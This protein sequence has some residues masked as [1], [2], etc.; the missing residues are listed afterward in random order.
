MLASVGI[1]VDIIFAAGVFRFNCNLADGFLNGKLPAST[2]THAGV[3]DGMD[4][5]GVGIHEIPVAVGRIEVAGDAK[6]QGSAAG[7]DYGVG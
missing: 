4:T 6:G 5:G 2:G 7:G 3:V 1:V